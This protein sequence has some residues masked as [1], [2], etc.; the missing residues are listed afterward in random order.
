VAAL[1]ARSRTS[2]S[3]AFVKSDIREISNRGLEFQ[4]AIIATCRNDLPQNRPISE[5]LVTDIEFAVTELLR[6]GQPK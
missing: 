2:T 6:S 4:Q 3:Q 1:Q 5:S